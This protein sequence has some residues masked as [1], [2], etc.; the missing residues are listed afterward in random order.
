[1][2][3]HTHQA[4]AAESVWLTHAVSSVVPSSQNPAKYQ[5]EIAIIIIINNNNHKLVSYKNLPRPSVSGGGE[6]ELNGNVV[7]R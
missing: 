5:K 4:S 3:A 2:W 6:E 7:M 1:M